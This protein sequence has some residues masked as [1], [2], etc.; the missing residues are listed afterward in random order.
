M[1]FVFKNVMVDTGVVDRL[2]DYFGRLPIPTFLTLALLFF[3]GSLVAS[4]TAV[5]TTFVPLALP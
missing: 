2:P 1:V 5:G 4:T 3:F